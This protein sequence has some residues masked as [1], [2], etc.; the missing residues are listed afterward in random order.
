MQEKKH[1]KCGQTQP[2]RQQ[3]P[4]NYTANVVK[5]DENDNKCRRKNTANVVKCSQNDNK[6]RVKTRQMFPAMKESKKPHRK[7]SQA[8]LYFYL[9]D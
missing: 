9:C 1:G 3:T 4:N 2:K 6:R 7:E 5:N 8:G